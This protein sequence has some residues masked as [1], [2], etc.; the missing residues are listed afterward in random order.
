MEYWTLGLVFVVGVIIGV[1]FTKR[2]LKL[3]ALGTIVVDRSDPEDGPYM[4]LEIEKREN[5]SKIMEQTQV[6][7]NVEHRNYLSR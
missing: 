2:A 1:I 4:F 3:P 7:L 6:V 5:M